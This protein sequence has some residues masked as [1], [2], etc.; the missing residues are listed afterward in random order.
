VTLPPD[1]T[2][3]RE[4]QRVAGIPPGTI[5]F[6]V[7]DEPVLVPDEIYIAYGLFISRGLTVDMKQPVNVF[8]QIEE[9]LDELM[10]VGKR[11]L[12]EGAE[13]VRFSLA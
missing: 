7:K 11:V 2:V 1:F 12:M 9:N 5:S 8:A 3:E 4:N 6:L 10:K 13:V